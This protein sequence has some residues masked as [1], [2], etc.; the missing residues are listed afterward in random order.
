MI[1]KK[2]CLKFLQFS[3]KN[4]CVGVSWK[5]ETPKPVFSYE[6]CEIF[7]NTYFEEYLWKTASDNASFFT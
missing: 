7:S 4:T 6:Y 5:T 2:R 3:Q 1:Y